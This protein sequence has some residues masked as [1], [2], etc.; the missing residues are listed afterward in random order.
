M[1]LDLLKIF[2]IRRV[3]TCYYYVVYIEFKTDRTL[4]VNFL[5]NYALFIYKNLTRKSIVPLKRSLKHKN[6]KKS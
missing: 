1:G 2:I 4:E 3:S 5:H 6:N